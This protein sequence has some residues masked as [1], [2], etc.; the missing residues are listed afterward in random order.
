MISCLV[1]LVNAN[2]CKLSLILIA[3]GS[4]ASSN[5]ATTPSTLKLI[6]SFETAE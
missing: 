5:S 6:P 1:L 4:V 2:R 3:V